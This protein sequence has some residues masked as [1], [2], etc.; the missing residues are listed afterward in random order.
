M[1]A[2]PPP[3]SAAANGCAAER[4]RYFRAV[5][6]VTRLCHTSPHI[7]GHLEKRVQD[8]MPEET[9]GTTAH[10][11]RAGLGLRLAVALGASALVGIVLER[12]LVG[13]VPG[14]LHALPG[15]LRWSPLRWWGWRST[16]WS[17]RRWRRSR[18]DLTVRYEAALADALADPLTGL[19]NHR[20]FQEE[21]DRQVD[22]AQ[23]YGA[24]VS[25]VL[26][27]LDDFKSD[28]RHQGPR[29]RRPG[30]GPLRRAGEAGPAQGGSVLPGR[31]RRVRHPP[32]A[33][34]WR[35]RQDRDPPPAGHRAAAGPAQP[36]RPGQPVLLGRHLRAARLRHR[37]R[38]AVQPGRCGA[39]CRQARRTHRGHRLR[40][41]QSTPTA[42]PSGEGAAVA[43]VVG[44]R[45]AASG[46]PTDHGAAR[47]ARLL[48]VRGAD[49]AHLAGAVRRSHQPVRG[50]RRQR[51]SAV[52]GA[53][54]RRDD[55]GRRR[56]AGAR[57]VPVDQPVA[58]HAGGAR[59]QHRRAAEHPGPPQLPAGAPGDRADRAAAGRPTSRRSASSS[60]PAAPPACGSPPTT[61]APATPACGCWPS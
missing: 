40:S 29:L 46:L 41:A 33:D 6:R 2:D 13:M 28:Q 39:L 48:G 7:R 15:Q 30:A 61:W 56:R 25:L 27:D 51:S 37:T 32:A 9:A 14:A 52:A 24:P 58:G 22:G 44:P 54:L 35:G 38:R 34:R 20:A 42:D 4:D 59:V 47:P 19:G 31:R 10:E 21:L 60:R 45:L 50:S 1:L 18:A 16:T 3:P 17:S 36:H 55:R 49:P 8:A 57:A 23:R 26:I 12:L 11:S 5:A 43:E 53:C